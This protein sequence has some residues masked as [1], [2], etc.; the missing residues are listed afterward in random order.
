[1]STEKLW[2]FGLMREAGGYRIVASGP[3]EARLRRELEQK[4]TTPTLVATLEE[5][6]GLAIGESQWK[7]WLPEAQGQSSETHS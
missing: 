6:P 3:S 1:M 5:L 2:F 7:P 4:Y